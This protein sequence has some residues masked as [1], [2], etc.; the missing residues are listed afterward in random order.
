MPAS[1]FSRSTEAHNQD[2]VSMSPI[3]ARDARAVIALTEEV[4]AI[5][6][7]SLCQALDLRGLDH[8]STAAREVHA[9]IREKAPFVDADR[10]M[11]ADIAAVLTMIRTGT[12]SGLATRLIDA[13][14]SASAVPANA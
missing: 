6:L 9:M 5:H 2:K 10:A 8:A 13:A 12:L 11:D 14:W 7:L 4:L 1:V 3:A